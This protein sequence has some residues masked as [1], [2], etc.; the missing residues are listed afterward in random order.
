MKLK[1]KIFCTNIGV[2]EGQLTKHKFYV[3]EEINSEN[4]RINNDEKKLKWYSKFY[5]E[6][7]E[8]SKIKSITVDDKIE[9]RN[10][11]CIEV[12]IEFENNIKYWTR[13][14]TSEYLSKLLQ[15]Q[16]FVT[17]NKMI[18]IEVLTN[19]NIIE[20]INYLDSVNELIENCNKY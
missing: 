7:E 17:G 10:C 1:D 19:E 4:I 2:Y 8:Q 5:F 9:N 6:L 14:T 11:D 3:V 13:F 12:T 20:V 18:I 15:H 16:K